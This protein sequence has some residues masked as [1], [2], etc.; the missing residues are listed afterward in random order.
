MA[1][2]HPLIL[3]ALLPFLPGCSARK[4]PP[5]RSPAATL[6]ATI[7]APIA[8]TIEIGM[9]P[10]QLVEIMERNGATDLTGAIFERTLAVEGNRTIYQDT[11]WLLKDNTLVHITLAAPERYKFKVDS[12]EICPTGVGVPDKLERVRTARRI[13]SLRLDEHKVPRNH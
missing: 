8:S 6:P 4:T 11:H 10:A 3:V 5:P 12:I 7:P 2:V 13:K 9:T 1:R